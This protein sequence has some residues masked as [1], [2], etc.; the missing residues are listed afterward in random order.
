MGSVL[1]AVDPTLDLG[2]GRCQIVRR[3]PTE[4]YRQRADSE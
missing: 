1:S 3:Q 2:V 4:G